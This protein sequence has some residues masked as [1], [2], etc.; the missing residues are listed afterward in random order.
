VR[1]VGIVVFGIAK[2]WETLEIYAPNITE[3]VDIEF[4]QHDP[5][6]RTAFAELVS[7]EM[8]AVAKS[9]P[10]QYVQL[11][12]RAHTIIDRVNAINRFR[13]NFKLQHTVYSGARVVT[14]LVRPQ[15]MPGRDA[16][17]RV[18]PLTAS[19]V[20]TSRLEGGNMLLL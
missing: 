5:Q 18:R 8:A 2:E 3:N 14:P 17:G 15:P 10:K 13:K 7:I 20:P 4:V 9:W 16:M 6:I 11:G 12:Q 1:L 19:V